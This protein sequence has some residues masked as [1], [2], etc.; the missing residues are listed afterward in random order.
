MQNCLLCV[1]F[2]DCKGKYQ[3]QEELA[4][5]EVSCLDGLYKLHLVQMP[6]VHSMSL[7][8]PKYLHLFTNEDAC[9]DKKRK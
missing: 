3:Y 4:S 6:S 2:K 9:I 5:E 8:P 7:P 1:K